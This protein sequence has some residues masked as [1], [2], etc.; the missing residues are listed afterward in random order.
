MGLKG[1]SVLL[2]R[3]AFRLVGG[4]LNLAPPALFVATEHPIYIVPALFCQY[5]AQNPALIRRSPEIPLSIGPYANF[6][7]A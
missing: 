3:I 1:L 4:L 6:F 7:E 2:F 5:L